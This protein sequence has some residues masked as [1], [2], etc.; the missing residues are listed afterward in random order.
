MQSSSQTHTISFRPLPIYS[1]E[2]F[3]KMG[4]TQAT[5]VKPAGSKFPFT[6]G[7]ELELV[8]KFK[9]G[10]YEQ[11]VRAYPEWRN[12]LRLEDMS[13]RN[14]KFALFIAELITKY[15]D[16]TIKCLAAA[17]KES[18]ELG[19]S[20]NF[21]DGVWQAAVDQTLHVNPN[22]GECKDYP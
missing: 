2:P 12:I 19:E 3:V 5:P 6:F 22:N 14:A 8:L 10:R 16:G 21:Y 18:K 1:F 17:S 9:P 4:N 20:G 11:A 7:P 15:S 13:N